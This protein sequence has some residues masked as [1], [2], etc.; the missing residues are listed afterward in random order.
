MLVRTLG[1]QHTIIPDRFQEASLKELIDLG[2]L[3]KLT[4]VTSVLSTL[5]LN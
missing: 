2:L 4:Y 1:A 5:L 3:S